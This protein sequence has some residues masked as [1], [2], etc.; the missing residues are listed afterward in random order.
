MQRNDF[1][2]LLIDAQKQETVDKDYKPEDDD[3]DDIHAELDRHHDVQYHTKSLGK[4]APLTYDEV[5]GQVR[6]NKT[7][8]FALLCLGF[9]DCILVLYSSFQLQLEYYFG[10]KIL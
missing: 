4:R 8:M 2:Q 9:F 6:T 3:A 1:L 5:F 10:K 7:C